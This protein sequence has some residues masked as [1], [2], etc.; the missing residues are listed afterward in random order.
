MKEIRDR[1]S[2]I[3]ECEGLT[4]NSFAERCGVKA[5]MLSHV[6]KGRNAPSVL[7]LQSILEAFPMYGS[8]W[9]I[10]GKGEITVSPSST[11][12]MANINLPLFDTVTEDPLP[13]K[14]PPSLSKDSSESKRSVM[15]SGKDI[16]KIIVLYEDGTFDC[17]SPQ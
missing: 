16:T 9:L 3:I 7:L 6:L 10:L 4:Q 12:K 13:D 8:D 1:I 17:F 14:I 15:N 5:A 2:Y 11:E